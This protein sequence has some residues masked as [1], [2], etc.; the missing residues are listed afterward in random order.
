MSE[1]REIP[2][3]SIKPDP[4]NPRFDLG[5]LREITEDIKA[6]GLI[7]PLVVRPGSWG[8]PTGECQDC[9]GLIERRTTGMLVEHTV[10]GV[11]CPGGS[12]PAADDWF[13]VAGH[14]RLAGVIAAGM[15]VVPCVI[16]RDPKTRAEVLVTMVRENQHRRD[17]TP[18][19]EAH[20]YEQMQL[21]G[22]T[23]VR[24]AQQTHR[25]KDHVE[26]RL[27]LLQLSPKAREDLKAGTMTLDDAEALVGL[28]PSGEANAL[29][30]IGTKEFKQ[31]VAREH[32]K[33]VGDANDE[34]VAERLRDEYLK[35]F[36]N[37]AQK[38]E[39]ERPVLREVVASLAA[40]LPRR[41]AME[42]ARRV[43]VTDPGALSSVPP[44]R[45]LLG[46]AAT[47]EKAP[48]MYAILDK[49]GYEK[50]PLEVTLLAGA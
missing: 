9:A 35:P 2:V 32:L 16:T 40:N 31:E 3:R 12:A 25:K 26:R 4:L 34:A 39:D 18:A 45:A 23:A 7:Q 1:F 11:P 15:R 10:G 30:S 50:S 14:R 8:K 22:L 24:I 27:S 43:G 20:A 44:F 38:A 33:L 42:W 19:E 47:V 48:G 29:R 5:D 6:S 17:L 21:E 46:L 41:T 49:L 36:L 28:T 13:V 37:G